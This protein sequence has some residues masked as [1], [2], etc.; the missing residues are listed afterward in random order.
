MIHGKLVVSALTKLAQGLSA[1]KPIGLN[2][3]GSA[4]NW[5]HYAHLEQNL[6][7][8]VTRFSEILPLRKF[9]KVFGNFM[10]NN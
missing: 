10:R 5:P 4:S 9:F 2:S 8:S 1:L 6:L 7:L 3:S